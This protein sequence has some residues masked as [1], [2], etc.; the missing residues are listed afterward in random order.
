[1]S[2]DIGFANSRKPQRSPLEGELTRDPDRPEI[3]PALIRTPIDLAP[4]P[5]CDLCD[6]WDRRRENARRGIGEASVAHCARQIA[7]HPH[8][9]AG[10]SG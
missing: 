3:P 5:G 9:R 1:M 4:V 2:G 6:W 10:D 7:A 8:R